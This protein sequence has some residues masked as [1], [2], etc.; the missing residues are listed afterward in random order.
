MRGL[1]FGSVNYP[2]QNSTK[3][4]IFQY[5]NNPI[6]FHTRAEFQAGVSKGLADVKQNI[7]KQCFLGNMLMLVFRKKHCSL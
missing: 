1:S 6:V 3:T 4:N 5:V 7:K 2:Y